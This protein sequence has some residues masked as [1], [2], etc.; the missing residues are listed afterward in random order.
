[1]DILAAVKWVTQRITGILVGILVL[2]VPFSIAWVLNLLRLWGTIDSL[3]L[4]NREWFWVL[5]V[6]S[7]MLFGACCIG[8][9]LAL[10]ALGKRKGFFWFRPERSSFHHDYEVNRVTVDKSGEIFLYFVWALLLSCA[11]EF[12]VRLVTL[13]PPPYWG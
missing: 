12:V 8:V 2:V 6:A 10:V 1:M 11:G 3:F 4:K 5:L 7:R 13:L 9:C